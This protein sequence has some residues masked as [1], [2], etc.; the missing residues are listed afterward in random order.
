MYESAGTTPPTMEDAFGYTNPSDSVRQMDEQLQSLG[1][2][3][4]ARVGTAGIWVRV[5]PTPRPA[6]GQ[7]E[8]ETVV[9]VDDGHVVVRDPREPMDAP[10]SQSYRR[11]RVSGTF[12][13][14]AAQGELHEAVGAPAVDWLLDGFN[15][16]FVSFGEVGTGKTY[17][18]FGGAGGE[19]SWQDGGLC[20]N[21][22][23]QLF[24]L[25]E[26]AEPG[27][28][29]VSLSCWEVVN[30]D[31]YDLLAYPVAGTASTNPR[32]INVRVNSAAAA[33]K[34]LERAR[35]GSQS[36]ARGN[37]DADSE[38]FVA[39]PNAGHS[40]VRL[41]LLN[42]AKRRCSTLHLVDLAGSQSL[43]RRMAPRAFQITAEDAKE[44]KNINQQL[45]AFSR[46]VSEMAEANEGATQ[47]KLVSARDSRL[48]QVLG[49]IMAQNTRTVF[50][51]T[52]SAELDHYN[53]TVA[54]LRTATRAMGIACQC[55]PTTLLP[56]AELSALQAA[57]DMPLDEIL[58]QAAG[59]VPLQ[60]VLSVRMINEIA[61]LDAS[62]QSSA[63]SAVSAHTAPSGPASSAPSSESS[64]TG[65]GSLN[66]Q[67][68]TLR[69]YM[70]KNFPGALGAE[71]TTESM[72]QTAAAAA[73]AADEDAD[74]DEREQAQT[75]SPVAKKR[76]TPAR[77][78]AT[79]EFHSA[80][81][82][83][84][85]SSRQYQREFEQISR[86][87]EQAE[88]QAKQMGIGAAAAGGV[89]STGIRDEFRSNFGN[90]ND[91]LYKGP[92]APEPETE[93]AQQQQQ[94][95]SGAAAED[96]ATLRMNYESL[97]SVLREVEME[98]GRLEGQV[99]E[100]QHEHAELE[101]QHELELDT[102]RVE[103]I[104]LQSKLRKSAG[105]A[106]FSEVFEMFEAQM[107]LLQKEVEQLREANLVLERQMLLGKDAGG[108][109]AGDGGG[110]VR[111]DSD[112]DDSAVSARY[113]A[114]TGA[115]EKR[116]E[117]VSRKVQQELQALRKE[118]A[119][120]KKKERLFAL[121]QK[122]FED[123]GKKIGKLS[124]EIG[125]REAQLRSEA[126]VTEEYERRIFEMEA[127]LNDANQREQHIHEGYVLDAVAV[128]VYTCRRLI[129][130]SNDCRYHESWKENEELKQRMRKMRSVSNFVLKMMNFVLKMMNFVLKLMNFVLKLM[131]F[132]RT[133]AVRRTPERGRHTARS[134]PQLGSTS[135]S[136]AS[137]S[138]VTCLLPRDASPTFNGYSN[139]STS[140]SV[141][142][143]F[144][145]IDL[146]ILRGLA[147]SGPNSSF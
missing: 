130:L 47:V 111:Y 44:R 43:D 75:R 146:L 82:E 39:L 113:S 80:A 36:W 147:F 10:T 125:A 13:A 21:A 12:A 139:R 59:M 29:A 31:T 79:R 45:L 140:R 115:H 81:E 135:S 114:R 128:C 24:R 8:P 72:P 57:G 71:E 46:V 14:E 145:Q 101:M 1:G 87:M 16:T 64:T 106:G 91:S 110:V 133:W 40:F 86:E 92:V 136:T 103:L 89:G 17:S 119:E 62:V 26:A 63:P 132:G 138:S 116:A 73:A 142:V 112:G 3:D 65:V 126:I 144:E 76:R 42:V 90:L 143:A 28:Y 56:P 33:L 124:K 109:G 52:V 99:E 67:M 83:S 48:T 2:G 23:S 51:A 98:K 55:V 137:A 30:S 134:R 19:L 37:V 127:I 108:G 5:A 27:S 35:A 54:T 120:M 50:L 53:D 77:E 22:V 78:A 74:A 94:A 104:E 107:E 60:H 85:A 4:L 105:R 123:A 118:N 122:G 15:S 84:Q 11:F 7:D 141:P 96:N 102:K 95:F 88:A 97:L 34:V 32:F 131:N 18:L 121:H 20:G 38:P 25:F 117:M 66:S 49:P 6:P 69:N 93:P 61:H 68:Q 41:T 129:D 70:S 9:G 100:L 58:G